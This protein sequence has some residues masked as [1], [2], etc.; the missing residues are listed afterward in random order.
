MFES[1]TLVEHL[2]RGV[3]GIGALWAAIWI[4]TDAGWPGTVASL[5]L[6]LLSLLAFR[7]CPVCWTLGLL[8]L[9]SRRISG[10]TRL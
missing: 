1:S 8:S 9:A 7:G 5:A 10:Q 2:V 3:M 6:G 4:G